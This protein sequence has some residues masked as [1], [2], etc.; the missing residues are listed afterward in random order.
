MLH[1]RTNE[2][3]QKY[4]NFITESMSYDVP[5]DTIISDILESYYSNIIDNNQLNT[6][7]KTFIDL[8][9][10]SLSEVLENKLDYRNNSFHDNLEKVNEFIETSTSK[11]T[12]LQPISD[13]VNIMSNYD[14]MENKHFNNHKEVGLTEDIDLRMVSI[15]ESDL[16]D[17]VMELFMN[18][19]IPDSYM[20]QYNLALKEYMES[21]S[22][23]LMESSRDMS[24]SDNSD[25]PSISP[26]ITDS[27]IFLFPNEYSLNDIL[28]K[29]KN[30]YFKH[31]IIESDFLTQDDILSFID[32]LD[33]SLDELP[34]GLAIKQLG[35]TL[36]AMLRYIWENRFYDYKLDACIELIKEIEKLYITNPC[37]ILRHVIIIL[38]CITKFMYFTFDSDSREALIISQT[39]ES[40]VRNL[41][42]MEQYEVKFRDGDCTKL[43]Q[44]L[45]VNT[46]VSRN[47]ES[48]L[49]KLSMDFPP[50]DTSKSKRTL[51]VDDDKSADKFI[52]ESSEMTVEHKPSELI[53][54]LCESFKI[55]KDGTIKVVVS[56]KSSY[57]D[58]YAE[59]HRLLLA[60]RKLKDYEGMKYNLVYHMILIDAIEKNV[61]YNKK[62]DKESEL[63]KDAVKARSFAQNDISTYLPE[64]R[65]NVKNFDLNSFYQ[66]VK[67]NKATITINGPDTISGVKTIIKSIL[68]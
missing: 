27:N 15:Q 53:E 17:F 58:E 39:I 26:Y 51:S 30:E 42:E 47:Q 52:N 21:T 28:S 38:L 20:N 35:T 18:G 37:D 63:Y 44:Q 61:L 24:T 11:F 3:I 13:I 41:D 23:D 2:Y 65:R 14:L 50:Y 59:N 6:Q 62:I 22:R 16:F 57:M 5:P 66:K 4:N 46:N 64:I 48:G 49:F 29:F 31:I 45:I 67:A 40:L 12:L 7:E 1:S 19:F 34:D 25:N 60:N 9:H 54:Y 68:L 55:Q 33:N 10:E 32:D 56:K 8:I 36:V 43:I